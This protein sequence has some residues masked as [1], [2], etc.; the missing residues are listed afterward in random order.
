MGTTR[1]ALTESKSDRSPPTGSQNSN[2][3]TLGA[4]DGGRFLPGTLLA[5]RYRIVGLLGR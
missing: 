2:A 3:P 5:G 4:H 1:S